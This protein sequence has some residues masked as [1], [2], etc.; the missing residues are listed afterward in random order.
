MPR[1]ARWILTLLVL[2]S[3]IVGCNATRSS[4]P[5]ATAPSP[6][7]TLQRS[8]S[9][10]VDRFVT[11]LMGLY[12]IPGAG[13]ALVQNGEVSYV[14]GY[15]VR[16]TATGAPVTPDTLFAVGSIT[17]SFTALGV[18]QLVDQGLIALDAPI[19]AH[20]PTFTL[21]DPSATQQVTAREL[22]AQTS[23]LPGGDDNLWYSGQITTLQQAVNYAASLNLAAAPGTVHIYSNY[24]YAIAG[25]LIEQVTGQV[26]T[27]YMR[28]HI[29]NPLGMSDATFDI[30]SMQ[31]T[32]DHAVPHSLDILK[33]M[34]PRPFVSL[35][36]IVSAGGLN[37]SARDMG[38]YVLLQLNNGTF[39]GVQLLSAALF[40]E[41]HRQQAA[42]PPQPP[43]GP[44]GF[45]T[46]GYAMGWFTADF[47]GRQVLWHNG[48]IDGFY[49]IV[50]FIPADNVGVAVLSN[51][52]LGTGSLFAL[53]AALGLLEQLLGVEPTRDVV[54]A[55]NEEAAFDPL[56]RQ[57]KLEAARAYHA[58]PAEWNPL[59]GDY[60][61][62]EGAFKVETRDGK[63]FL[64]PPGAG[65]QPLELVP[66]GPTSFLVPNH[67][68][69]GL[70]ITYTFVPG[71]NSLLMLVRDGAQVGYKVPS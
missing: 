55:L 21:A 4:R 28:D 70:I 68:R 37:A 26:W 64:I 67:V 30:P 7:S 8:E 41:M 19:V 69:D 38:N 39:Q 14:Q 61:G 43:I 3:L 60:S 27:S 2:A 53:A 66:Y 31:Q 42:Y 24:N 20:L 44:T 57:A 51:A 13:V 54:A 40:N 35:A 34:Q 32:P 16:S 59:L 5:E 47:N 25:Y 11:D 6:T 56:D 62:A 17:K 36:G 18:L 22:L 23:G 10:D 12:D 46:N 45:Q 50:M 63:L 15:G 9:P 52:G 65:S 48:S 71:D 33:G 58:D 1:L 29:L 49:A